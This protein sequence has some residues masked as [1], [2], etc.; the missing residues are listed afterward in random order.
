[1]NKKEKLKEGK[2]KE[3]D[4]QKQ[5]EKISNER[6]RKALIFLKYFL[7]LILISFISIYIFTSSIKNKLI[8]EKQKQDKILIYELN[9][10]KENKNNLSNKE[11]EKKVLN[12]LKNLSDVNKF[13][14]L[15]N[16]EKEALNKYYN[17]Y[18]LEENI[19]GSNV[20]KIYKDILNKYLLSL[21]P[22]L[23]FIALI[24]LIYKINEKKVQLD[25][26][27]NISEIL[28]GNKKIDINKQTETIYS[29]L[30][31]TIY[32]ALVEIINKRIIEEEKRKNFEK[33]IADIS[34]QI[35]MPVSNISLSLYNINESLKE[36]LLEIL[37]NTNNI[38]STNN[39]KKL[40]ISLKIKEIEKAIKEVNN[41]SFLIEEL[42]KIA[43]LE[44]NSVVFKKQD[45]E[46]NEFIHEL[47]DKYKYF[48][49]LNDVE[50]V[51]EENEKENNEK[52]QNKKEIFIADKNWEYEAIGNIIKNAIEHSLP[53]SKIYISFKKGLI[54]DKIIVKD[55]AGGISPKDLKNMF[56]RFYKGKNSKKE[57][58]GIG[59]NI[60]KMI[61]EGQGGY[62][63]VRTK[64]GK[65][66]IFEINH[67]QK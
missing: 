34:H 1:M 4:I 55:E 6:K 64:I 45:I 67:I 48:A 36:E 16:E 50:I 51:L 3:S 46:Y 38:D 57:S 31:S 23:I 7:I 52:S 18:S 33:S 40:S 8:N 60:T 58:I 27:K 20:E 9:K 47:I 29:K 15:E 5:K 13:N 56:S 63:K 10:L 22:I 2:E 44:S 41:I 21:L 61:I 39:T 65:G 25:I 37:E 17:I 24:L 12:I 54:Y 43:R 59:L 28:K 49:E 32:K 53:K 42:L 14:L 19:K 11:Y 62:I 66:T 26:E 30:Q 35:R